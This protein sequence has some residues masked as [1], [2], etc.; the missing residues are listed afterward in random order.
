MVNFHKGLSDPDAFRELL[1]GIRGVAPGRSALA[2]GT[3]VVV[4]CP[5][6][7]LQVFEETHARFFFGRETDIQYLLETLE[8]S[9]FLAVLGPSGSG[10]SSLVRAGLLPQLRS[11][12]LP[13]SHQW[14]YAVIKPGPHPLL[15]LALR[16]TPEGENAL[17]KALQLLQQLESDHR[18]LH[19][20]VRLALGGDTAERR[21]CIIVDQFEEVFTLCTD[22]VERERFID[23]LLYAGTVARGGTVVI[24]TMR[25]DFLARAAASRTL[26]DV[27]STH[28]YL[29]GP[30][31]EDQLRRAVE[32]PARIAGASLEEGLTDTILQEMS[33]EPGILPL[34]EHALAQIWQRRHADETMTLQAYREIGGI[35][36]ALARE[37]EEIFASFT[38]EQQHIARRILLR[39]TQPGE[40]TEDTRRRA[41][42][43]ELIGRAEERETVEEIVHVLT[44]A[45]L[46]VTGGDEQVDIAHEALIRGWPR[47]RQWIDS[48]PAALRMHRR[49]IEGV[50]EW[51]RLKQD[52]G[53]LFRGALLAQALEWRAQY[54][55]ELNVEEREFLDASMAR[56]AYEQASEQAVAEWQRRAA[57][58][59]SRQLAAEA[60]SLG[61]HDH[62]LALL[63]SVEAHR[64]ADTVEARKGLLYALGG[65]PVVMS[66][67]AAHGDYL[68]SLAVNAEGTVIVSGGEDKN[69]VFWDAH[70]QVLGSPAAAHAAAVIS[71]AVAPDGATLASGSRDKTVQLWDLATRRLSGRPLEGHDAAVL[72]VAFHP[73]GRLLASGSDDRTIRRWDVQ[74]RRPLGQPLVGHQSAVWRLA[75]SRDGSVLASASRDRTVMLWDTSNWELLTP[76]LTGHTGD[77]LAVAFTPDGAMLASAGRDGTI[78]LWDVR[79]G[80]PLGPPL[81]GH[82]A[83]IWALAIS[84]DGTM[85]AS[86][87]RNGTVVLW[88]TATREP[89]GPALEVHSRDIANVLFCADGAW[90]VSA[91]WD[92][93]V[94]IWDARPDSWREQA[95]RR[96]QRG[97]TPEETE[98]YLGTGAERLTYPESPPHG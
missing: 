33:A 39:L 7:G 53:A 66:F 47:L 11:G 77:V 32:E 46:L 19:L 9:R 31:D 96:A 5:Y 81:V 83:A 16:V 14:N 28:Q 59:A 18:A 93:N 52:P 24:L 29:V 51:Q 50:Q 23:L 37:A 61:E 12:A 43:S 95:C 6:R 90:L 38:P 86:G 98:K 17:G 67:D 2:V 91:S 42:R 8:A 89:L 13:A 87:D 88:D 82:E 3:A 72:S 54:P 65:V 68:R 35:R 71:L 85:L 20:H 57:H 60:I 56:Q 70:G 22:E 45:R 41:R 30:M 97:L 62:D 69:V 25:A 10:K 55:D 34:L 73:H 26:A 15:E 4:E 44:E 75:F 78:I 80:K 40:G 64:K 74:T 36:G 1:A 84:P 58:S 63:L 21:F 92:G 27:L 79:A 48:D 94:V 76:P 49:I